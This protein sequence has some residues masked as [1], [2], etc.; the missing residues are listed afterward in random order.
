MKA[1]AAGFTHLLLLAVAL[2]AYGHDGGGGIDLKPRPAAAATALGE[3]GLA[4]IA[5]PGGFTSNPALIACAGTREI[6]LGYGGL[7]EGLPA[8]VTSVSA[9]MPAGASIEVPGTGEVGRRFGLAVCLNH[10]GLELSQGTSWGWNLLSVGAGCRLAPYGSAGLALKYLISASDLDGSGVQAFGAD[11]GAV[12]DLTSRVSL[13]LAVDNLFGSAAWD[14]GQSEA[15]P[16]SFSVGGWFGL[17]YGAS[18][19][20]SGTVSGANPGKTGIGIAVPVATTG[21]S[22]R[23]GY[24]GYG[25]DYR[26]YALTGGFG[27]KYGGFQLDYGVKVD[28]DLALGTT[29]HVSFGY[30]LP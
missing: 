10:G 26:R 13:G 7:V 25:G 8:S 15:P 28:D 16:T 11:V 17:P 14:D 1:M 12:L 4:R 30:G 18:G 5:G 22:V 9:S 19:Q 3:T 23:A 21:F 27:L 2:S 20:L 24:I 6:T 29:H